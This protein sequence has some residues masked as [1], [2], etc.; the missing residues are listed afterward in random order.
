MPR[1]GI[2]PAIPPSKLLQTYTLDLSATG[3]G[4]SIIKAMCYIIPENIFIS[5]P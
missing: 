4:A 3:I 5:P 2:E 1:E